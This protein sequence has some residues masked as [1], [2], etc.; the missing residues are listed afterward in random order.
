MNRALYRKIAWSNLQKNR[1]TYFPYM[2]T[3]ICAAAMYYIM[4]SLYD[5]PATGNGTMKAFLEIGVNVLKVFCFIFL[6]YTNSFL[7]KQRKK[8]F[9]LY[10]LLGMEKKHIS[11]IIGSESLYIFVISTVFGLLSGILF[12]KL[13]FLIFLRMRDFSI[14]YQFAISK[15]AL[16]DSIYL[17]TVIF[18]AILITSIWQIYRA[19]AIELIREEKQGEKE[20]RSKWCLAAVGFVMLGA[21]YWISVTTDNIMQLLGLFFIAVVLVMFGTYFLFIAGT[22]VILKILKANKSYYYQSRHFISISGIMYRMKQNAAGLA[23]ICLLSASVLVMISATA[24]LY[25][26]I[27]K[28]LLERFPKEI[29]LK[30][31]DY[32]N[33][34][35]EQLWQLVET[36][37]NKYNL[38][39]EDLIQFKFRTLSVTLRG[40]EGIYQPS[41]YDNIDKYNLILVSYEE[42]KDILPLEVIEDDNQ[43]ILLSNGKRYGRSDINLYGMKFN[44]TEQFDLFHGFNLQGTYNLDMSPR[45]YLVVKDFRVIEQICQSIEAAEHLTIPALCS[46]IGFNLTSSSADD[47]QFADFYKFIDDTAE[48][49]LEIDSRR[50]SK[51]YFLE[52]YGGMFF[53]GIFLTIVFLMATVLIIYYKQLSEGYADQNRFKI[54]VKVGLSRREVRGCIHSQ[55]LMMFFLPLLVAFLHTVFAAPAITRILRMLNMVDT[56]LFSMVSMIVAVV[57]AVVYSSVYLLTAKV[58]ER[59]VNY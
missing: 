22:V 35:E 36:G 43:A 2:I 6:F 44:I 20:P 21:G 46:Q 18:A 59:I 55:I 9:G 13:V 56:S 24:T 3:W 57:F 28:A 54:M 15:S 33:A 31:N 29:E 37:L 5:N 1:K 42:F 10:H 16:L 12:S 48:D 58:Y 49:Y 4:Y 38:K 39:K 41:Q 17:F 34:K 32:S 52:L 25:L 14:K 50:Y 47:R 8:E 11:S 45:Y 27:D 40:E 19:N 26:G 23:T 7:M 30:I 53:L 51:S